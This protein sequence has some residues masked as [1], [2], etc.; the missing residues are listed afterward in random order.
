MAGLYDRRSGTS[1]SSARKNLYNIYDGTSSYTCIDDNYDRILCDDSYAS[2]QTINKGSNNNPIYNNP[3]TLNSFD[4]G[5]RPL[6]P[7][8][9]FA[10]KNINSAQTRRFVDTRNVQIQDTA[11]YFPVQANYNRQLTPDEYFGKHINT[12]AE[13]NL[14]NVNTHQFDLTQQKILKEKQID[15]TYIKEYE[16][17]N[18]AVKPKKRRFIALFTL[19][20][21]I[22]LAISVYFILND[23]VFVAKNINIDGLNKYGYK[24][25]LNVAGIKEG[26]SL[27]RI[28]TKE[29]E[30]RI[31]NRNDLELIKL[32]FVYP[33]GIYIKILEK[34]P[35][36]IVSSN[37]Y[38]Y[39]LDK[40]SDLI[41]RADGIKDTSGLIKVTNCSMTRNLVNGK[42]E[43]KHEWQ[44]KAF[45][46]VFNALYDLNM[47]D[48][49]S[50]L[51]LA[52][53]HS[54]YLYTQDG[55]IINL[56]DASKAVE[57][58]VASSSMLKYIKATGKKEGRIDV[59]NPSK[60]V[61]ASEESKVFYNPKY[62][63][64]MSPLEYERSL[65]E[66]SDMP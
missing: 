39:L 62:E 56:G 4:D 9:F 54:I 34:K 63:L 5:I 52:K 14:D 58:L 19:V 50:L 32:N 10:R 59:S 29:V 37:G 11:M 7:D 60:P 24:D 48:N 49:I 40:N 16:N 61:F 27:S 51:S 66:N 22:T 43:I 41:D 46:S 6:S 64:E 3:G 20:L 25:I 23:V 12:D 13:Y 57:K 33:N 21:L 55:F 53:H 8:E 1:S 17:K 36:A 30:K 15:E 35:V 28:N 44:K 38:F 65:Q 26:Q 31:N 45:I 2:S 42:N 47:L 18:Q